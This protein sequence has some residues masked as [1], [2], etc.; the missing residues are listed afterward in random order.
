MK[1][2][3]GRLGGRAVRVGV[4]VAVFLAAQP[5]NR[6][7][8]QDSQFGIKGLGTPGRWES[9][10]ARST[11]GA[12]APFDAFSPLTD[13]SLADASRMSASIA[14][15]TSWRTIEPTGAAQ[16]S[17]RATRFPALVIA[18]PLTRRI[19]VGG[20]F[21]TYLDRTFGVMIQDTINL[22]G[23]QEPIT[24]EITSDG[25]VSDLRLAAAARLHRRLALGFGFHMLTGSSRVIATRTFADSANYRTSTARDEVAYSGTGGSASLL[26]DVTR[27]LRLA[28]WLRSDSRLRAD[29]GGRQVAD[30]NLPLTYGAGLQWRAG[31]QAAFAG[32]VMWR[33]WRAAS[34]ADS[35]SHD[36][37][38][39]SVGAELGSLGTPMRFGVR[40]GQLP[41][42][43]GKTPSEVGYSAG[44]G[45]QF[46]GGRGRLDIGLERLE[47]KGMGLTERVWTFLVGLTVRP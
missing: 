24:D 22:R 21:T 37:F 38:N 29:I 11:G 23:V 25:A 47:R 35:N 36:T 42:G 12:F 10:R 27:D 40:G 44:L 34:P 16:A 9:V 15:G 13:A 18:G 14:G 19:V 6:L 30:N 1:T 45:R 32:T 41:F 5:P 28:G 33:N 7:T 17:L 8:A 20:G 4:L 31:T 39:W 43:V 46:S 26:L 3:V 2:A